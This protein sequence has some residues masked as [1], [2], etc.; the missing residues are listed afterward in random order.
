M[1]V[2]SAE[3]TLVGQADRDQV[4]SLPLQHLL[5]VDIRMVPNSRARAAARSGVRPTTAQRST[6]G[7]SAYTRACSRPHHGPVPTTATLVRWS[8]VTVPLSVGVAGLRITRVVDTAT[9]LGD[10]GVEAA[11]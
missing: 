10:V 11:G 2:T 6:S 5:E 9:F 1:T 8:C 4:G 3:V 7:R